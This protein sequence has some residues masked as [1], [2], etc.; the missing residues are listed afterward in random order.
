MTSIPFSKYHGAGNDFIM[1]DDR[2]GIW[3]PRMT[4]EWIAMACHRRFGIGADG[5]IL[6]QQ[7]PEG[8]DF[9]MKYYNADGRASTFCGN[10]GR[11][12]VAFA[13]ALGVHSG[14]CDFLGT[15][16]WHHG[17]MI[18]GERVTIS[19]SD[20]LAIQ[21]L[22]PDAM[23]LYT[24]SPHYVAFAEHVE[25]MDVF[26]EG[27]NIRYS[28]MFAAEGINVN[29]VQFLRPGEI[30]VRTYE[31]GVEDETYACGTGVVAAAIASAVQFEPTVSSWKIHAK[32][33]DLQVD[34][35][36]QGPE[37]FE[38]VKL[39]GPAVEVFKGTLPIPI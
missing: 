38:Q 26:T 19:M 20:V 5:L 27:R 22:G 10:G 36:K 13:A 21:R 35:I 30:R 18:S 33:G 37:H 29:F 39:T 8:G 31:R 28:D 14:R 24:G 1:I 15:D 4:T 9:F 16:G 6:V 25:S 17:E 11:C 7:S 3:G 34:F 12:I 23:T 2:E 32:G